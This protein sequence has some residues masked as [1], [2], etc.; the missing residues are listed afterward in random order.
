MRETE[1][2]R[3]QNRDFQEGRAKVLFHVQRL[4]LQRPLDT[5][6]TPAERAGA[7]AVRQWFTNRFCADGVT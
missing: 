5:I 4:E 3:P 1:P 2:K 7:A 6:A